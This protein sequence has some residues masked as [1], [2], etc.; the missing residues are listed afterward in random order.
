MPGKVSVRLEPSREAEVAPSPELRRRSIW[1]VLLALLV[2]V[3]AL[4][5]LFARPQSLGFLWPAAMPAGLSGRITA[6]AAIVIFAATYLA[7]AIG[8]L[9][10]FS[11]DRP[12]AAFIGA[13]L[14]VGFGVL[15][16]REAYQAI[17]F[18]T[19]AL[20]LGVMIVVGSLRLSGFFRLL[21]GW[22]VRRAR[23]PLILLSGLVCL[24]G[25]LSAL[26]VNDGI[27]L[28]LTPLVLE[29]ARR[30]RRRPVP[31]LLGLA[32]AS[33]AGSVATITGNPQNMMI[34]SWS[35]I[36]YAAFAGALAPVAAVGLLLTIVLLVLAYPSEFCTRDLLADEP[37]PGNPDGASATRSAVIALGMVVAFFLGVAPARAAVCAAA[38]VLLSR[39]VASQKIYLEVD[40]TLL[41]LFVGLF[42]VAAGLERS[43]LTPKIVAALAGVYLSSVPALTAVTAA[44]SN[45]VSNVPAVL[46]LKPFVASLPDPRSGWLTVAAASTLAGNLTLVGSVANL[47]VVQRARERGV[48]IGFWEYFRVGAPLTV[49]ALAAAVLLL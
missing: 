27:C 28:A 36:P 34:G 42:I 38:L 14:M 9:P 22:I 29:V 48:S 32:M 30:A 33:N 43:V 46:V 35:Q 41:L 44:L 18:D 40:W 23:H 2:G 11:V 15:T 13:S 24:S 21:A 1:P 3:A 6:L 49:A 5:L 7:V 45:L 39:K 12:A 26:L 25:F 47:I 37:G 8:R 17:D 10:G 31:Y 19:L 20:L 16:L 4:S